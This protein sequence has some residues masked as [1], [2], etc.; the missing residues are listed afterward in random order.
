MS[1]DQ[2]DRPS[3]TPCVITRALE[4][5]ERVERLRNGDTSPLLHRFLAQPRCLTFAHSR[6]GQ[7]TFGSESQR[8][9]VKLFQL[10]PHHLE[11]EPLF[12]ASP[13]SR[14]N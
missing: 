9:F 5:T 8:L 11:R 12:D 10:F 1:L 6:C 14:S 2:P 4:R 7:A 13:R 3:S